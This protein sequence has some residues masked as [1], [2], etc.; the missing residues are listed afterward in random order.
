MTPTEEKFLAAWKAWDLHPRDPIAAGKHM[1]MILALSLEAA[2]AGLDIGWLDISRRLA[3]FRRRGVDYTRSLR[4]ALEQE[5]Y[6][7]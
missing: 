2:E 6:D 4:L 5:E 1:D 3:F 7:E